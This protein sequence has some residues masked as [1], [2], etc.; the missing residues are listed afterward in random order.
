M[1]Q[2]YDTFLESIRSDISIFNFKIRMVNGSRMTLPK[3]LIAVG[4]LVLQW[5]FT[6]KVDQNLTK[7]SKLSYQIGITPTITVF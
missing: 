2:K 7:C 3:S 6:V 5:Y 4:Y 1:R